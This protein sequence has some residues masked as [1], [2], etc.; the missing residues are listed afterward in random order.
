MDCGSS[1]D[2]AGEA[3]V[4]RV[5]AFADGRDARQRETIR[6]ATDS[7]TLIPP[8]VRPRFWAVSFRPEELLR[9]VA[10]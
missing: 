9:G 6:V 10:G 5:C 8:W 3:G 1:D 2:E 7:R 4:G